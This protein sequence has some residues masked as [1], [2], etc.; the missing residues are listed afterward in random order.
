MKNWVLE[1]QKKSSL[2][3]ALLLVL[4][5]PVWVPFFSVLLFSP[6]GHG[7]Q[8]FDIKLWVPAVYLLFYGGIGEIPRTLP[9]FILFIGIP[10]AIFY[11]P[12]RFIISRVTK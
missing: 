12:I 10:W 9:G 1:N 4:L 11:I 2:I 8:G 5:L 3:I 6:I 7:S